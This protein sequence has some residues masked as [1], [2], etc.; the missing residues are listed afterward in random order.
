MRRPFFISESDPVA[1]RSFA[2]ARGVG[3]REAYF[4]LVAFPSMTVDQAPVSGAI[5]NLKV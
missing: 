1:P 3:S 2:P 5:S 4:V